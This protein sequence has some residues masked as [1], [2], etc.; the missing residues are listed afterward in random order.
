MTRYPVRD[1]A[2]RGDPLPVREECEQR[3]TVRI[4]GFK[5]YN[6]A[7][8]GT[9]QEDILLTLR[10]P[11]GD[12]SRGALIGDVVE[13]FLNYMCVDNPEDLV[14]REFRANFVERDSKYFVTSFS[15]PKKMVESTQSEKNILASEPQTCCA[16]DGLSILNSVGIEV[17]EEEKRCFE[18]GWERAYQKCGGDLI[19]TTRF[20][21][22]DY[23]PREFDDGDQNL[24]GVMQAR[25][26]EFGSRMRKIQLDE[27]VKK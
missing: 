19:E 9:S 10:S 25:D 4:T 15:T 14:G 20:L 6:F 13:K 2:Y 11:R 12:I 26:S 3:R 27:K 5:P 17:S 23:L 7:G 21:Y 22:S 18:G 1:I 16:A 24:F 8:N